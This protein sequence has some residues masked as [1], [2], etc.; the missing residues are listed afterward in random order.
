MRRNTFWLA[1]SRALR[2]EFEGIAYTFGFVTMRYPANAE[3]RLD[4]PFSSRRPS[5]LC[6][7]KSDAFYLSGCGVKRR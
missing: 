7:E 6:R 4:A 3:A 2:M 1:F 5:R